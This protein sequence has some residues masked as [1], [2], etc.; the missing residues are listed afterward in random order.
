[1]LEQQTSQLLLVSTLQPVPPAGSR[2]EGPKVQ[3][4]AVQSALRQREREASAGAP[5]LRPLGAAGGAGPPPGLR[6]VCDGW[7]AL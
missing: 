4:D 5:G 6:T 1:M 2:P 3:L 7:R